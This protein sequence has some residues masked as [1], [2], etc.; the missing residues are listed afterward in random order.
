M[1]KGEDFITDGDKLV[2]LF[3]L[4][5][6]EFLKSYSYLVEEDYDQTIAKIKEFL[7]KQE[8]SLVDD[9]GYGYTYTEETSQPVFLP[10]SHFIGFKGIGVRRG[11]IKSL[12]KLGDKSTL[13]IFKDRN[14]L[15]VCVEVD[16]KFEDVIKLLNRGGSI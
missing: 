16:V 11:D 5:K 1:N 13:I 3:Q 7:N 14:D 6:E 12:S 9:Y 4:S 15:E 2:D 10:E 8:D